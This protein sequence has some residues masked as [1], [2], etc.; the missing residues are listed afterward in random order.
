M[1]C[2]IL[3]K[4]NPI[5]P[6]LSNGRAGSC[7]IARVI[8]TI[9]LYLFTVQPFIPAIRYPQYEIRLDA[10]WRQLA[11]TTYLWLTAFITFTTSDIS[12]TSCTRT[13]DTPAAAHNATVAAV[14]NTRSVGFSLPV[15]LPINAFLLVPASTR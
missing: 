6:N 10:I 3:F 9:S 12:A 8:S 4:T 1:R 11:K 2:G 7:Y 15:I 5:K 14:P 13:I